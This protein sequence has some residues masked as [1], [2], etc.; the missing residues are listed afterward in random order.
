MRSNVFVIESGETNFAD[1]NALPCFSCLLSFFFFFLNLELRDQSGGRD[2][3]KSR[4][5]FSRVID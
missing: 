5:I 2:W 4:F 3:E 1:L